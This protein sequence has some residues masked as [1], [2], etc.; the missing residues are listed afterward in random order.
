MD[1]NDKKKYPNYEEKSIND[2]TDKQD[3]DIM[4][5]ISN[6]SSDNDITDIDEILEVEDEEF[7]ELEQLEKIKR[8]KR[9]IY[10]ITLIIILLISSLSVFLLGHR[11]ILSNGLS[12][13]KYLNIEEVK[14]DNPITIA[15]LDTGLESFSSISSD[16]IL[17]YVDFINGEDKMSDKDGHGTSISNVIASD[18]IQRGIAPYANLVILKVLD[19]DNKNLQGLIDALNW[20]LE[21]HKQYNI[22][23]VNISLVIT[24]EGNSSCDMLFQMLYDEGIIV[25]GASGNTNSVKKPAK[26]NTVISVGAITNNSTYSKDD[27]TAIINYPYNE[28]QYIDFY[29]FGDGITLL[30]P[31]INEYVVMSGSSYSAAI[32]SGIIA[33][34]YNEKNLSVDNVKDFLSEILYLP[35]GY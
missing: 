33:N 28:R 32:V 34:Y 21:N 7:L 13:N 35:A 15:I 23:V 4:S 6:D 5:V 16:R 30:D 1:D 8:K 26:L 22:K 20:I 31:R 24:T 25:V 2:N 29:T 10:A 27:D 9:T 18:G 11:T 17:K 19:K 14:D 3:I 12:I